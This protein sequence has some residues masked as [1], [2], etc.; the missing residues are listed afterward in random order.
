MKLIVSNHKMNLTLEEIK[1]YVEEIESLSLV[2]NAL[3]FCPSF[4][5]LPYFQGKNYSLGSQNVADQKMGA[6]TGE[7]SVEQLK[8]LGVSY[9]IVGHSERRKILKESL[10]TIQ[11]KTDL[12]LESEIIPILCIGE[13]LD[14]QSVKEEILKKEIDSVLK[15]E[16]KYEKVII[17]YEPIWAIGTGITPTEEEIKQTIQKIKSHVKER[18]SINCKVLY[19]GSVTPENIEQLDKIEWIDGYLIGGTSLDIPKLKEVIKVLEA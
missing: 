6:L 15:S 7:V 12:C 14:E 19:G 13:S 8:S 4:P 10:E 9:V 11:R 1:D 16:K 18:Y 5:Y 3:V 2:K 17:A